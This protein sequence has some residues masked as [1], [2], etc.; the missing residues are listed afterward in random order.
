M[1]YIHDTHMA[2]YIPPTAFHFST[3]TM[4]QTA[5]QVTGTIAM[6]RA[7]GNQTSLITIPVMIPSNSVGLKGSYLTSVELDYENT[8]AAISTSMTPSVFK[9]TRGADTAVAVV[10]TLTS[11]YTPAQAN[12]LLVDQVRCTV[13]LTTPIWIDNDEYVLVQFALVAGAGGNTTE[14]YGAVANFT[15]RL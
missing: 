8:T 11:T 6:H 15:A 1:G 13:T 9:V 7:A 4:T 2:Q 12:L 10:S 14:F 3:A 5:G